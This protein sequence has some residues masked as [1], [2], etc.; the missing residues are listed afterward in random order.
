MLKPPAATLAHSAPAD[1]FPIL[2]RCPRSRA[3]RSAPVRRR[4]RAGRGELGRRRGV[5][6]RL[7]RPQRR[8]KT[9]TMRITLGV[10]AAD[11][12]RSMAGRVVDGAARR[13]FGYIPRSVGSTRRCPCSSS[14]CTW[15]G[16][17]TS[18][19]R[20]REARPEI[21]EILQAI[22]DQDRVEALSLGNQ[23]RV[24]LAAALVR[25]RTSSSWTSRSR[26]SIRSAPTSSSRSWIA[27]E[28]AGFAIV[29]SSHN[30]SWWSGCAT[31]RD[32]RPRTDRHRG[33]RS[34]SSARPGRGGSC[35]VDVVGAPKDWISSS[36]GPAR[37]RGSG[38]VVLELA[39]DADD[40]RVLDLRARSARSG[41]S[42]SFGRHW[43]ALPE[44]VSA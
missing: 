28:D 34:T 36:R 12:E 43:P 38:R 2:T 29:F 6:G 23:Q 24:Q 20:P 11:A 25:S 39:N 37:S 33:A 19:Q 30:W 27:T 18:A 41:T 17:T 22:L 21:L 35:A 40:Q 32:D 13:R 4:R 7:R 5:D 26:D 42:A 8:G 15:R 10:L 14:S 1:P 44:V 9:T 3:D 31:G 16:C